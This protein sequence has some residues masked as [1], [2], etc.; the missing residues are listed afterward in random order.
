MLYVFNRFTVASLGP[1]QGNFF[2]DYLAARLNAKSDVSFPQ[3]PIVSDVLKSGS[4]V[5]SKDYS[6]IKKIL[7]MY[8]EKDREAWLVE[9]RMNEQTGGRTGQESLFDKFR[10]FLKMYEEC[11]QS[12]LQTLQR[13]NLSNINLSIAVLFS[14][15]D[16]RVIDRDKGNFEKGRLSSMMSYA[17]EHIFPLLYDILKGGYETNVSGH[18]ERDTYENWYKEIE[19][20]GSIKLCKRGT[21]QPCITFSI[22]LGKEFFQDVMRAGLQEIE[23]DISNVIGD[24]LWITYLVASVKLRRYALE[25][26]SYFKEVYKY[27][28]KNVNLSEISDNVDKVLDSLSSDFLSRYNDKLTLLEV[29]DIKLQYEYLKL[30]IASALILI[31]L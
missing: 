25:K 17:E 11:E 8:F 18:T 5:S 2:Q 12:F 21:N 24:D 23:Q 28:S 16:Y 13:K 22:K 9:I 14:Q 19:N 15:Y 6:K 27:V 4:C 10:D 1:R 7:D 31:A 30:L 20:G 3:I 26:K 29:N